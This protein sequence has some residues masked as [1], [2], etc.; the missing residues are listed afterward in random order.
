MN[1]ATCSQPIRLLL[2]SL[3]FSGVGENIYAARG[4]QSSLPVTSAFET[5]L[6]QARSS[7]ASTRSRQQRLQQSAREVRKDL[8]QIRQTIALLK[9]AEDKMRRLERELKSFS[10]IPPLKMLK[11][12]EAGLKKLRESVSRVRTKA[13]TVRRQAID[14]NISR[15]KRFESQVATT[16]TK[17]RGLES[18]VQQAQ[19]QVTQTRQ[20]FEANVSD[21]R[22]RSTVEQAA[23]AGREGLRP[24]NSA[25]SQIDAI[26]RDAET[27]LRSA[28]AKLKQAV[29]LRS[30]VDKF[31]RKMNPIDRKVRDLAGVVNKKLGFKV[32]FS[33]KRVSF[34]V[35]TIL[36]SPDRVLGVA[37]KPLTKLAKNLL[38]PL[39]KKIQFDLKP[40]AELAR[41]SESLDH[42]KNLSL[43]LDAVESKL[44]SATES[45]SLTKVESGLQQFIGKTSGLH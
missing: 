2:A 13:E 10:R 41:F 15:I 43:N 11:T 34:S 19:Q 45:R 44:R 30:A 36:E 1:L 42:L 28:S 39:T 32:P 38:S 37:V 21:S 29:S 23:G 40:P 8:E 9:S 35:R 17:L 31:N 3:I 18:Q 25:L 14:P 6:S 20:L 27:R 16:V 12:L 7:I 24:L 4:S 26:G 5:D 22:I 33:K